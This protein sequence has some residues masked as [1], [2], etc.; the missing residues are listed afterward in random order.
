MDRVKSC[1]GVLADLSLR[2]AENHGPVRGA[3]I[4][5]YRGGP[6]EDLKAT[7]SQHILII[8]SRFAARFERAVGRHNSVSYVRAP[9]A[10]SLVPAGVCPLI[11]TRSDFEM[12]ACALDFTLVKGIDVEL[13]RR[14][15]G[16]FRVRTNFE[17]P[18]HNKLLELLFTDGDTLHTTIF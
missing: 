10:L 13:D 3:A 5:R 17:D 16:E 11:S 2:S 12:V 9:D 4:E 8:G 15:A 6:N 18:A 1:D 7:S 14:P